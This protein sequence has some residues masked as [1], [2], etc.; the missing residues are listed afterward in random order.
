[1]QQNVLVKKIYT[2]VIN[3]GNC[4][5]CGLCE[6]LTSNLFKMKKSSNGPLPKLVRKPISKDIPQLERILLACPGRGF[7]YQFLSK[8][9]DA[10]KKN[11]FLGNYNNLYIGSSN[12]K[13]TREKS[14][15]G[16]IVR[17]LLIE[18]IKSNKI[19]YACILDENK[20]QIL[21]FNL[22]ITSKIDEIL[23]CSQSIYQ[24]TPTLN[25]LKTL[26][27]NKR[28]AFVG[29]PEHIAS[30]RVLKI[31]FP[32]E[33][34]HIKYLISIY[35]GTNMYPGSVEFFLKGNGI[36]NLGEVKKIY[37]RYGEWPGLLRVETKSNKILSLKKFY[38]NYLIP[39]FIS[40]NCLITPD[41]TGELSD[42]SI[43]D[44]WSPVLE[45]SGHG[46]SIVISRSASFDKILNNLKQKEV[47]SLKKNDEKLTMEMHSHMLE[48]KK[49]GSYLRI[50]KLSKKGPVPLYDLKPSHVSAQRKLIEEIIGLIIRLAA[51]K[52]T[53]NIF[54]LVS[55]NILGF[56][57]E[58]LRKIWKSITKPTK[59]KGFLKRN[60]IEIK[61]DRLEEF[62]QNIK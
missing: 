16:G 8:K 34:K 58:L 25:K 9:I 10:N 39:F 49:I 32:D 22:L 42:I 51:S 21:D 18:L 24:T 37:W 7:P 15:S 52:K 44:A 53:K 3:P 31:Y 30:L 28:Y 19:D 59:R 55:S 1:M 13:T 26:K 11:Q 14:S 40:K 17:T 50:R 23:N 35:S 4:F 60:F 38:Y 29:L 57:F 54:S 20:N 47:I 33:F 41:F 56:I 46:Y 6:G 2:D 43:G 45:K 62:I 48:F 61:N 36:K 27:K 5:H 12:S